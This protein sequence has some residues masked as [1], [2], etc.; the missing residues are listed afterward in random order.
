MYPYD[1][2]NNNGST[3]SSQRVLLQNNT[4]YFI[5]LTSSIRIWFR[6]TEVLLTTST[7]ASTDSIN[8]KSKIKIFTG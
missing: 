7:S 6:G 2:Y 1:Y 5:N 3:T 8:D 4:N